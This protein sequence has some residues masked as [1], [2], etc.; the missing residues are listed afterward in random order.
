MN[1]LWLKFK[2]WFKTTLVSILAVYLILFI[3]NNTGADRR[4]YFWWWFGQIPQTSVFILALLSFVAGVLVSLLV[5]TT[6]TTIK[7]FKQIKAAK[8]VRERE[9]MVLKAARIQQKSAA[10]ASAAET[11]PDTI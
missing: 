7:Q 4:V 8:A 5:R 2:F 11:D 3:Y 10:S 1:D 6:I 9:E